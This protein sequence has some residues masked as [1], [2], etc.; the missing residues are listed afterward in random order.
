[1]RKLKM[2]K[3][4][5]L[6]AASVAALSLSAHA[7]AASAQSGVYVNANGGW[8]F[9]KDTSEGTIQNGQKTNKNYVLGANIGYDYMM[10]QNVLVGIEGGYT[11]FGKT[12]YTNA[13][14]ND[15]SF[16]EKNT[17]Y[18]ILATSTYVMTNGWNFFG[19]LGAAHEKTDIT[20]AT[21]DG[22][23]I[24]TNGDVNK[25]EPAA[26]VGAGYMFNQNVNVVA[27][28]EHIF[29]QSWDTQAKP[30]KPMTQDALTLGLTYKFAM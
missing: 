9:A 15:L 3:R 20:D 23:S 17:A 11:S 16:S 12:N 2:L 25:W 28:W 29:G 8:S 30:T 13:G 22:T 6:I 10:N 27:Q 21:L 4:I 19:K 18:Q 7:F 14:T 1:M 24:S 5:T 26:A